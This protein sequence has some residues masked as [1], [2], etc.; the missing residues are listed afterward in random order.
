MFNPCFICGFE[1]CLPATPEEPF[2]KLAT[3]GG[4]TQ[5]IALIEG[6]P[7]VNAGDN[8][9]LLKNVTG[10]AADVID[11]QRGFRRVTG[12]R[13]DIGAFESANSVANLFV[14]VLADQ[15]AKP[16]PGDIVTYTIRLV[17]NGGGTFINGK[18]I[19]RDVKLTVA[20]PEGTTFESF[21]TVFGQNFQVDA[22]HP[23][24][25]SGATGE[26]SLFQPEWRA[27][28]FSNSLLKVKV[29]ESHRTIVQVTKVST[30]SEETS[31]A[32]NQL[33]I[34]IAQAPQVAFAT[35]QATPPTSVGVPVTSQIQFNAPINSASITTDDF[36]GSGSANSLIQSVTQ[37]GDDNTTFNVTFIPQQPGFTSLTLSDTAEFEF[38]DNVDDPETFT[39]LA[40]FEPVIEVSD[41]FFVDSASDVVDNNFGP[42]QFTLREA[43]QFANEHPGDDKIEFAPNLG[44]IT[45]TQGELVLADTAGVLR[46]NG[47]D[48]S[49]LDPEGKVVAPTQVIQRSASDPNH[50]R[51][52]RVDAGAQANLNFLTIANGF[53]DD[54]GGG[55]LNSGIL[56]VDHSTLRNN[57]AA[58]GGGAIYNVAST[59]NADNSMSFGNVTLRNSTLFANQA[60]NG[61]ALYIESA[62]A[63]SSA[64]IQDS[65]VS[66]NFAR[67][68]GGGIYDV[69]NVLISG[70]TVV[71]NQAD[72]DQNG[73]GDSGGIAAFNFE[74]LV[75]SIV[76]GNT[77]GAAQTSSDIGGGFIDV[78]DHSLVADNPTG[79]AVT[80][81]V[82][83]N[84]PRARSSSTAAR[85]AAKARRSERRSL[86][87]LVLWPVSRPRR[88]SLPATMGQ[89]N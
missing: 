19:A 58:N 76:A 47:P 34:S 46:I 20:I 11:D 12:T 36:R 4:L 50:F 24:P 42:G 77:R 71:L 9:K 63:A 14:D 45:L 15:T 85:S 7:A 78:S 49:L 89:E 55:I 80:N 53:S 2:P 59:L 1:P 69:G 26:F 13:V 21:E 40:L 54:N 31:T 84:N 30:T 72:S 43:I 66:G 37:V 22:T 73:S 44:S 60:N 65:T 75:N 88:A 52:F 32:D 79:G 61:G 86:A 23:L 68:N 10:L 33:T 18:A 74:T 64:I 83:G 67:E 70:C 6:S 62:G 27:E 25:V 41:T 87:L 5:T 48:G 39:P 3:N 38:G 51:I 35:R 81:G 57:Q 17:N 56:S 29:V 28:V 82:N 8:S 16:V